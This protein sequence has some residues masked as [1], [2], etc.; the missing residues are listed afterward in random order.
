MKQRNK[1]ERER[2]NTTM[3]EIIMCKYYSLGKTKNLPMEVHLQQWTLIISN[4]W[5]KNYFYLDLMTL[6]S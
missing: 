3:M 5:E 1:E 4:Q 2:S 6:K